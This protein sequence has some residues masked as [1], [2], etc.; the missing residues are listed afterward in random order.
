M[1]QDISDP[2]VPI[3][4]DLLPELQQDASPKAAAP[5]LNATAALFT[6]ASQT[7]VP[8]SSPSNSGNPA[9]AAPETPE[10][11]LSAEQS[12]IPPISVLENA[13]NPSRSRHDPENTDMHPEYDIADDP[14]V[15]IVGD[16]TYF[17]MATDFSDIIKDGESKNVCRNRVRDY[18]IRKYED[19]VNLHV[20]GMKDVRQLIILFSKDTTRN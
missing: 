12:V 8:P 6:P 3:T 14:N 19:F 18:F 13:P 9:S 4:F 1:D 15:A 16:I 17:R 2:L 7:V 10:I 20:T 11:P 5:E